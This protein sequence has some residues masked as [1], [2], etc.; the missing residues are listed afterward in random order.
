M[1]DIPVSIDLADL[2]G[3]HYHSGVAF[4]AYCAKL[5][6]AV[7]LGGRYDGVGKAFGRARPATGFTLYLLDLAR[8]APDEP[9]PGCI[10]APRTN[11]PAL[12][13]AVARLRRAGEMVIQELPG[14]A[15]TRDETR[16]ERQL[17]KRNGK[18]QVRKI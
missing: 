18:W 8:L 5:P 7:A 16:C 1:E 13:A 14:H 17:I 10:L 9:G 2:R 11:D 3:Y 12:A 6:N 15:G 4:A